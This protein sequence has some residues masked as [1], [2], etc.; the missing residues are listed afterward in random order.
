MAKQRGRPF[1][2]TTRPQFRDFI[3][4]DE[5]KKLVKIAKKQAETKPELLKFV[6]EQIFGRAPQPLTGKDGNDLF[7]APILGSKSTNDL[8]G[9][10]SASQAPQAQEENP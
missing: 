9:N 10:N 7:P 6:L 8:S 4:E 5:V 2:S 1:G 3:T